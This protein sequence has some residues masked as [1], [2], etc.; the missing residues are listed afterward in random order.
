MKTRISRNLLIVVT[1]VFVSSLFPSGAALIQNPE[2][3]DIPLGANWTLTA[4]AEVAPK[5]SL[6]PVYGETGYSLAINVGTHPG[7]TP[8]GA[9]Q[10]IPTNP[11]D[12]WTFRGWVFH[13]DNDMLSYAAAVATISFPNGTVFSTGDL[14]ATYDKK[15]DEFTLSGE[16]PAGVNELKFSL[17]AR[18][19]SEGDANVSSGKVFFDHVSAEL[20]QAVPEPSTVWAIAAVALPVLCRIS[21]RFCQARRGRRG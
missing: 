1:S 2:F 21:N 19:W 11:G 17:L 12:K 14:P 10:L 3:S 9:F 5:N 4:D 18:R 16:T 13:F 6:N 20:L 7:T 8:L 15:W